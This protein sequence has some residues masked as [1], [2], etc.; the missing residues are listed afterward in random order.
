MDFLTGHNVELGALYSKLHRLF[1]EIRARPQ[2]T[3]SLSTRKS[4]QHPAFCSLVLSALLPAGRFYSFRYFC[5]LCSLVLFALLSLI[6]VSCAQ[7]PDRQN[8]QG[9]PLHGQHS[10]S[11]EIR[12]NGAQNAAA[13]VFVSNCRLRYELHGNTPLERLVLLADLESGAVRLLNPT[14]KRCLEAS[15]AP[16][17]WLY[18]EYMLEAFPQIMRPRILTH[19]TQELGEE[20]LAGYRARKI[21]VVNTEKLLGEERVITRVFWLSEKFCVQLRQEEGVLQRNFTNIVVGQ[22]AESLFTLPGEYSKVDT[23]A[24]FL[25]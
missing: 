22:L 5:A 6:F 13:K 21:R 10:Y 14:N 9:S 25:K 17:R 2:R 23:I 20:T 4:M 8:F 16:L 19:E 15:F 11:G 1:T 7:Q 24:E 3:G 18:P 12:E